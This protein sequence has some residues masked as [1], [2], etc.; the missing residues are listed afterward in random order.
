MNYGIAAGVHPQSRPIMILVRKAGVFRPDLSCLNCGRIIRLG[1]LM[2][3]D[4]PDVGSVETHLTQKKSLRY[5]YLLPAVVVLT[6]GMHLAEANVA[7]I[8][9]QQHMPYI[10]LMQATLATI[11]L[12][13]ANRTSGMQ[14]DIL[15]AAFRNDLPLQASPADIENI[16]KMVDLVLED[17][18]G[19]PP[20]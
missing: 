11:T 13:Q 16:V 5:L 17:Y 19:S 8:G 20:L 15:S 4:N 14:K 3:R 10:L 6:M 9:H 18:C 12:E 1:P 7:I 2:S